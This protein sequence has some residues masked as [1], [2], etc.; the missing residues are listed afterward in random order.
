MISARCKR[1][2][3][4]LFDC[5]ELENL[6]NKR[7]QCRGCPSI[8]QVEERYIF[9]GGKQVKTLVYYNIRARQDQRKYH[10]VLVYD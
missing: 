5:P 2:G 7:I 3:S 9:R 8:Y 6:G 10:P 1:C 4:L